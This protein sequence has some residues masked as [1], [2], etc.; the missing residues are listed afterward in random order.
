MTSFPY[1]FFPIH[2]LPSAASTFFSPFFS[3]QQHLQLAAASFGATS[4]QREWVLFKR[5]HFVQPKGVSFLPGIG[6]LFMA[7]V[8]FSSFFFDWHL[9]FTTFVFLSGIGFFSSIS[10]VSHPLSVPF[11]I[12]SWCIYHMLGK[13]SKKFVYIPI[14]IHFYVK[15]FLVII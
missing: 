13:I 14:S 4:S 10:S 1:L 3:S 11:P 5:R 6:I 15:T 12:F 7:G 9:R 2:V 8:G